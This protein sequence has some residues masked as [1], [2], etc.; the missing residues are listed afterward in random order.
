MVTGQR[1]HR[2][3]KD[4]W[5]GHGLSSADVS[6]RVRGGLTNLV[7]SASSR[8]LWDILRANVLT[9]F[10]AIVAGSFVLLLLRQCA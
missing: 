7:S 6:E 1:T 4:R 2:F 3:G 8:S 5:R 9:L 10:N